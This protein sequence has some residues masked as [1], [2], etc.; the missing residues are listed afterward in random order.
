MTSAEF[1]KRLKDIATN[2]KTLYVKGCF[3][4]PLTVT[5]KQ[6][7]INNGASNGYNAKF[8]RKTKILQASD[9][10]FGFDCVCLIKGLLWGWCGDKSKNYG[11][12]IYASNNVPDINADSMIDKCYDLSADFS[13]M[14]PGEVVWIKGHVGVYI[15]DNLVVECTPQWSNNVQIT[16]CNCVKDGYNRRTW[17]KHGKLPYIEYVLVDNPVSDFKVGDIVQFTGT[18]H[19]RSSSGT[20]KYACRS[21]KAK[22][23]L[24]NKNG[25]HPYHL[26]AV[27]GGESTVYGWVDSDSFVKI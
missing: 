2:Y 4:A 18:V 16:A 26:V 24:I 9:D 23:T 1:V 19:Y 21:G 7:Y 20:I 14:F 27:S 17:K 8:D 11:G 22:I 15:G 3:G 5:N 25:K 10:T 13:N 12:A 6:R